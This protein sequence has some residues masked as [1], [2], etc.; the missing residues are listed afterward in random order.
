ML[1][2]AQVSKEQRRRDL[3]DA[4]SGRRS[5]AETIGSSG[6]FDGGARRA[7]PA[8]SESHEQTLTRVLRTGEANAGHSI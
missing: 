4:L 3:L 2:A 6:S 5:A 7:L 1:D 8:T